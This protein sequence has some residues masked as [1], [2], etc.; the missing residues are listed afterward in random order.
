M[1]DSSFCLIID[2]QAM[3]VALGTTGKAVIFGDVADT[4]VGAVLKA[5]YSYG[6]I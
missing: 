5:G 4:Y 1:Y 2:G 3:V 6:L